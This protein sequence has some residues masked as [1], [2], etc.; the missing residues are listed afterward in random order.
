MWVSGSLIRSSTWR[1]SSVSA[2]CISSSICLPSSPERSR[3]MRGSF[4]QAL[5][6]GCIRVFMTPS[7]SS[8][9]T[10]ES[11]CSGTLNS[12]SSLRREISRSWLR[13]STSSDTMVIRCS[14][15]STLTRIDWLA[16]CR[17]PG[18]RHLGWRPIC[19]A[20]FSASCRSPSGSQPWRG[21]LRLAA[22]PAARRQEPAQALAP[23]R[24][25][26][27]PRSRSRGTRAPVRPARLRPDATDAPGSAPPACPA[28]TAGCRRDR[29]GAPARPMQPPCPP[30]RVRPSLPAPDQI[31]IG[32]FGFGLGRLEP[33]RISLMRSMVVRISDTASA[34]HRHAVA[35]FAHQ[36]LAGMRQRFQ[37]RQSEKAAGALD[38]VNQ[39][40]D[41]IQDLGVVRILLE[42]H[43]LIVDGVQALVR[44]RQKLPQ[45]I[46]HQNIPS[47]SSMSQVIF[48]R[49][50][51]KLTAGW[52][53][54]PF[55]ERSVSRC[56]GADR[57]SRWNS[58]NSS[59][60]SPA[61]HFPL[62]K[63][64]VQIRRTAGQFDR[65]AAAAGLRKRG[66]T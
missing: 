9:V 38:G 30:C 48:S 37:P 18:R 28:S 14:S 53:D 20:A 24:A 21:R 56:T 2:P 35:E 55:S 64:S 11:R 33:A 12:V 32:A 58:C 17:L 47:E 26:A 57:D 8:A 23:L 50:A 49:R 31:L 15:V 44:L 36:R 61:C 65:R 19:A 66:R 51:P 41:V 42:P 7:C 46:I 5:P 10:L 39:A 16:T 59:I 60:A 43:Q 40:E 6:I 3:T 1:S 54:F 22:A 27:R 52:P 29:R 34:G 25:R 63:T 4:C 62:I 45:Q 13:V